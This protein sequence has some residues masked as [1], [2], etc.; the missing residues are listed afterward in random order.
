MYDFEEQ[1]F[2]VRSFS[3]RQFSVMDSTLYQVTDRLGMFF[4]A[5]IKLYERGELK[6]KEFKER[7]VN[8]FEDKTYAVQVR[9]AVGNRMSFSAGVRYFSQLR[10]VYRGR[11]RELEHTVR[12]YGPTSTIL[13]TVGT[14]TQLSVSGWYEFQ[15]QSG[16]PDRSIANVAMNL[17]V[18]L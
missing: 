17:S 1:V 16:T 6:W 8:Y 2:S 15:E 14:R 4:G 7:P 9:Y 18:R 13:W 10:F 5:H 3:Y 12:S 11:D